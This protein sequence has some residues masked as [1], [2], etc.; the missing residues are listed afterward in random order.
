MKAF[1]DSSDGSASLEAATGAEADVEGGF[2][3]GAG[4]VCAAAAAI[5]QIRTSALF[6]MMSF[7]D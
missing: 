4:A 7:Q 6:N 5:R 2:S 3:A 1:T